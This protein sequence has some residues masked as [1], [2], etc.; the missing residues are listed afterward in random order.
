MGLGVAV[1]VTVGGGL[2][3]CVNVWVRLSYNA[4]IE[5]LVRVGLELVRA[6]I[7]IRTGPT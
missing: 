6:G 7:R 5:V 1:G 3:V 4:G 2:K